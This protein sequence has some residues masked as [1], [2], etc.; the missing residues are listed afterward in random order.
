[1]GLQAEA[2]PV[3]TWK[4]STDPQFSENVCNVIGLYVAPPESAPVLRVDD[5][6]QIQ[7]LDRTAEYSP[8]VR[9]SCAMSHFPGGT[10]WGYRGEN[11]WSQHHLR[12]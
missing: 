5:K 6:S 7:A 11:R 2:A 3:E 10:C 9:H 1:M 12:L 8:A 4:L